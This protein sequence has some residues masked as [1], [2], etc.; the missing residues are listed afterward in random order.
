MAAFGPGDPHDPHVRTAL[1]VVRVATA[2]VLLVLIAWLVIDRNHGGVEYLALLLGA[3][4][5]VLGLPLL[6]Q[7]LK[8]GD[9]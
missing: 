3:L 4:G 5:A 7:Y 8:K 9:Q 2:I 6:A 1:E